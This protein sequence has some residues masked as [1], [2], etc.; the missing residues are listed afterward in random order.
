M[1]KD[2]T[3]LVLHRIIIYLSL[4]WLF[5]SFAGI[6]L[7]PWIDDY[8]NEWRM[9]EIILLLFSAVGL[10]LLPSTELRHHRH[11]L[12]IAA[13]INGCYVLLLIFGIH[14]VTAYLTLSLNILLV[15][16][17][18][19]FAMAFKK[20]QVWFNHALAGISLTPIPSIVYLLTS[21]MIQITDPNY[22]SVGHNTFGNIRYFNDALLPLLMIL[23]LRP[24]FLANQRF[25]P[26]IFILSTLYLFVFFYDGARAVLLSLTIGILL[27]M[28]LGQHKRAALTLPLMTVI[29]AFT[30]YVV[31]NV[32]MLQDAQLYGVT[33]TTSSGRMD[34]Y[35]FSL[36]TFM[37][38]VYIGMGAG[39]FISEDGNQL[40]HPHNFMLYWLAEM[41]LMGLMLNLL[42][43]YLLVCLLSYA[44]QLPAWLWVSVFVL[45]SNGALSGSLIYPI[46]QWLT[47]MLMA[48][49]YAALPSTSTAQPLA[50]VIYVY[51]HKGL[52]VIT[53]ILIMLS[54][55][56]A[57]PYIRHEMLSRETD[58]TDD[59]MLINRAFGPA[60]WQHNP[61]IA[62]PSESK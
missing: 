47:L 43:L 3:H 44:D 62:W 30:L 22:T 42:C 33:R 40:A 51:G 12:K 46:S 17:F 41:G 61:I 28:V 32:L 39:H 25:T 1:T 6:D 26:W 38:N 13:L 5:G 8:Y 10:I 56:Y 31:F 57:W 29:C 19:Y 7:N 23:W 52:A 50:P 45:M 11:A 18:L 59:P 55:Y 27:I 9:G 16:A 48:Y 58:A 15:M 36:Q 14:N 20:D 24:G 2:R 49:A 21:V 35:L 37:D 4:I 53:S 54:T 34:L 60:T